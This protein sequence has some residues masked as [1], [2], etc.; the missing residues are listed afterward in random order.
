MMDIAKKYTNVNK[1]AYLITSFQ[2]MEEY[3]NKW[4]NIEVLRRVM[5][6]G[7]ASIYINFKYE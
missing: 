3:D 1:G 5:S 7:P 6:W 2:N 4:K